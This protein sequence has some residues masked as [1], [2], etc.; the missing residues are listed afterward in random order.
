MVST[1]EAGL[2]HVA[3]RV[4]R[5]TGSIAAVSTVLLAATLLVP[6]LLGFERYVISGGSMAGTF[7]RGAVAFERPVPVEDLA[8]GDVITY[9]PPADSGLTSLVTHRIVDKAQSPDGGIVLRTK[10]DANAA[11]DPW[12]FRLSETTQPRLEFTVPALGHVFL[13]LGDRSTRILLVG[14]PAGLVA[15]YSLGELVGALRARRRDD[16]HAATEHTSSGAAPSPQQV[17]QPVVA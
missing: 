8:V 12:R 15:L 2:R 6:T 4:L 11:P 14:V 9:L 13:A 1:T 5:M 16:E 3:A 17:T 10:G 7:E